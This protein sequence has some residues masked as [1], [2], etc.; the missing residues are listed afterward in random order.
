M[1]LPK[2]EDTIAAN[3]KIFKVATVSIIEEKKK[4]DGRHGIRSTKKKKCQ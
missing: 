4:R 2:V 1:L 3:K